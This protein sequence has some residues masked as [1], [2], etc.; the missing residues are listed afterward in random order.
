MEITCS[1]C[2]KRFVLPEERLPSR[3]GVFQLSC[4]ACKGRITVDLD[5]HGREEPPQRFPMEMGE[6]VEE[7][8]PYE[9]GLSQ[10]LVCED[11]PYRRNLLCNALGKL[12]YWTVSGLNPEEIRERLRFTQYDLIV[13]NEGYAGST[14]E[15]NPVLNHIRLMPMAVR[16]KIFLVLISPHYRTADRMAAFVKS[17][18]LVVN[19]NDVR[20]IQAILKKGVDENTKFYQFFLE[21]MREVGK[22]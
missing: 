14:P 16:R 5:G 10:A 21:C 6:T 7:E 18:N 22:F 13:L 3:G 1:G 4:P 12:G 11:E 15:E 2:K 20:N 8:S 9:E 19:L 17:A